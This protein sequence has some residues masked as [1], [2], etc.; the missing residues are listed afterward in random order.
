MLHY[1]ITFILGMV[2]TII[3][4]FVA[5]YFYGRRAANRKSK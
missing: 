4:E 1:A 5:V 3:V 2:T